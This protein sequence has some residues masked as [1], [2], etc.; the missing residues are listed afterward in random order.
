MT[1][2]QETQL[3]QRLKPRSLQMLLCSEVIAPSA[4]VFDL[5]SGSTLP[6]ACSLATCFLLPS[7]Q[8][9]ETHPRSEIPGQC[10]RV[11]TPWGC[12]PVPSVCCFPWASHHL[13]TPASLALP[14]PS[15]PRGFSECTVG[16][17]PAQPTFPEPLPRHSPGPKLGPCS[18]RVA[19]P[20]LPSAQNQLGSLGPGASH[21]G[22]P[23]VFLWDCYI[24]QFIGD[25]MI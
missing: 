23:R 25:Y 9:P 4:S 19:T 12:R 18:H 1:G 13:A 14:S 8:R 5:N 11:P 24:Y 7:P 22:G 10:H 3:G 6:E 15:D 2:S 17:A 21:A 16:Q 20:L